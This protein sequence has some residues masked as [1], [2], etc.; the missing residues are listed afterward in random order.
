MAC[1]TIKLTNIERECKNSV[2][3]VKDI[4]IADRAEITDITVDTTSETITAIKEPKFAHWSFR[5]ET[6]SLNSTSNID[7]AAG[8]QYVS[9]ELALQFSRMESV[10]RLQIKAATVGDFA[11][12]VRDGNDKLHFLGYDNPISVTAGTATT[13]TA[14][15][16]FNGYNITFTDLS[17]DYPM[18][19][20]MTKDELTAIGI[21]F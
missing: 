14:M 2:G 4:W 19:V 1:T 20:V 9:T 8:T 7:N 18:E 21:V 3:G 15:G 17:K 12:I 16:D 5:P 6:A 10:K 13:G 11:I